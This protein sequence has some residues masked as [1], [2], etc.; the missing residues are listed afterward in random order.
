[1]FCGAT[2]TVHAQ[3]KA[4]ARQNVFRKKDVLNLTGAN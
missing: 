3:Q 4:M 2:V 1:V